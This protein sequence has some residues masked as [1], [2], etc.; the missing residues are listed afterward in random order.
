MTTE[1]TKTQIFNPRVIN[2]NKKDYIKENIQYFTEFF[3]DFKAFFVQTID[4]YPGEHYFASYHEVDI[5]EAMHLKKIFENMFE[6]WDIDLK[7]IYNN[8]TK[9]IEN[10]IENEIETVF[11]CFEDFNNF[12]ESTINCNK[13]QHH[14]AI[15]Y[16][17][18]ELE[19]IKYK[20][21]F[22]SILDYNGFEM[23]DFIGVKHD[24]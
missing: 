21:V 11:K 16:N 10:L 20:K 23:D 1:N 8:N 17:C 19:A 18:E 9:Y 4:D 2:Q 24:F 3:L 22:D 5:Y 13:D 14:F 6:V 12:F 15:V 7:E